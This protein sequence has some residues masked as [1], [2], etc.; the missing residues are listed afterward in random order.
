MSSKNETIDFTDIVNIIEHNEDKQMLLHYALHA[1][2]LDIALVAGT[3]NS[4][5]KYKFPMQH[6]EILDL[7]ET[8]GVNHVEL[9]TIFKAAKEDSCDNVLM[10]LVAVGLSLD[11]ESM[12]YSA[13]F[14]VLVSLWNQSLKKHHPNIS[15][16]ELRKAIEKNIELMV[17]LEKHRMPFFLLANDIL[18]KQLA[19]FRDAIIADPERGSK[20]LYDDTR[21]RLDQFF[22]TDGVSEIK[23]RDTERIVEDDLTSD[24]N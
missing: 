19:K 23:Q 4:H 20:Q 2:C 21:E 6:E 8:V 5:Q 7:I 3:F 18:P 24:Q 12:A 16:A 22:Q 11:E 9:S 1:N 13:L 17:L 15:D 14:L 10:T